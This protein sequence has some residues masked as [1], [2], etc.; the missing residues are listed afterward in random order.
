MCSTVGNAGTRAEQD[1]RVQEITRPVRAHFELKW[2]AGG[3]LSEQ[4]RIFKVVRIFNPWRVC[5][6]V[7]IGAQFSALL[8]DLMSLPFF[9][10]ALHTPSVTDMAAEFPTYLALATGIQ[11]P[12]LEV[13]VMGRFSLAAEAEALLE[14]WR[15]HK[16]Q[17][18]NLFKAVKAIVVITP[19][20]ATVERVF[21]L[22]NATFGDSATQSAADYVQATI[23][24]QYN[25]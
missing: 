23:Q 12:M 19:S 24:A 21:S 8:T 15:A 9:A 2:S 17:L 11:P 20:S 7:G 4:M 14:W 3:Q 10:A 25:K 6:I 18:P 5:D 22:L 1:A 13:N 16:V